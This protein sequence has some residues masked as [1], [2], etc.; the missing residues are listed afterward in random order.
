MNEAYTHPVECHILGQL[1]IFY[2]RPMW[3]MSKHSIPLKPPIWESRISLQ[4]DVPV[5]N[6]P[7]TCNWKLSKFRW[8]NMPMR[9]AILAML[10]AWYLGMWLQS[11]THESTCSMK[12]CYK[13]KF[14]TKTRWATKN[15]LVGQIWPTG[16]Y[17]GIPDLHHQ[18]NY[19]HL[20]CG[21]CY[22][23]LCTCPR[24]GR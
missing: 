8:P 2:M 1:L 10:T 11:N 14:S 6:F 19:N 5:K 15:L 20:T 22:V 18:H 16:R 9:K 13:L 3:F 23:S 12:M 7:F 21:L 4:T 24:A 17:W